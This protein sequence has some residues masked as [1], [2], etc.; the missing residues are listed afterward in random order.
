M[1]DKVDLN[2][3]FQ[4]KEKMQLLWGANDKIQNDNSPTSPT[5]DKPN[6]SLKQNVEIKRNLRK[7]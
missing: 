6:L 5:Q 2:R 7:Q 4:L 3:N 1:L